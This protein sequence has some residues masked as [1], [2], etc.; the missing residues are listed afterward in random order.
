[1]QFCRLQDISIHVEIKGKVSALMSF[2]EG[3]SKGRESRQVN[4]LPLFLLQIVVSAVQALKVQF[5]VLQ[6]CSQFLALLLQL[7]H[8][9]LHIFIISLHISQLQ[10][11][12][13][14]TRFTGDSAIY[15]SVD[16]YFVDICLG[17]R[18]IQSFLPSSQDAF[19]SAAQSQACPQ[20]PAGVSFWWSPLHEWLG[21]ILSATRLLEKRHKLHQRSMWQLRT[22]FG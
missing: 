19:C 14:H 12:Q 21:Y 3:L 4:W 10:S 5:S 18:I 17:F 15:N 9:A 20:T 16:Y 1:M 11:P 6:L 13:S 22:S 7:L 8:W 2:L